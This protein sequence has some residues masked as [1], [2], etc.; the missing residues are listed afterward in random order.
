MSFGLE[1]YND[2]GDLRLRH[3]RKVCRL[4]ARFVAPAGES[5]SGE[6]DLTGVTNP[7]FVAMPQINDDFLRHVP[8][9][10]TFNKA[11]GLVTWEPGEYENISGFSQEAQFRDSSTLILVFGYG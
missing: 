4:V 7:S 3:D 10:V 11:N 6:A 1:T 9:Q 2:L 8:H 5:G